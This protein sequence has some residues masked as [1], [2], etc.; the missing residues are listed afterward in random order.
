MGQCATGDRKQ[1]R[2][3]DLKDF[4]EGCLGRWA[5]LS[6]LYLLKLTLQGKLKVREDR[7][8]WYWE[9]RNEGQEGGGICTSISKLSLEEDVSLKGFCTGVG[10]KRVVPWCSVGYASPGISTGQSSCVGQRWWR[11]WASSWGGGLKPN[12]PFLTLSS[13][14]R[15]EENC[16]KSLLVIGRGVC[17][18]LFF[19]L[20]FS[21]TVHPVLLACRVV[22]RP[23]SGLFFHPESRGQ[24]CQ[25]Y[26]FILRCFYCN[27]QIV[28]CVN[29]IC[30][31]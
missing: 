14:S 12:G 22:V 17:F 18:V 16:S 2:R 8:S 27:R 31:W 11:H 23:A 10:V 13:V 30:H 19:N 9:S 24:T 25:S 28:C 20:L 6:C 1:G 26:C 5:S 29:T 3:Y 15:P 21:L 4:C 7:A